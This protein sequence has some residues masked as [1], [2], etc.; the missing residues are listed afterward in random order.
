MTSQDVQEK[1]IRRFGRRAGT[2]TELVCFPHAGGAASYFKPL[3]DALTGSVDVASVQYPGRHERRLE[4]MVDSIDR[5]ADLVAEVLAL[6]PPRPRV[7]FGHSMG[8]LVAFEVARRLPPEHSAAV[9]H[10]VASGRRAPSRYRAENVHTRD[11]AGVIE[12]L[13]SLNGTEAV[14]LRDPDIVEMIL[15]GVR[16]DYRAVETYRHTAGS[17]VACP[18]T[19]LVGDADPKVSLEEAE[20]WREHTTDAFHMHV[21][22]GGHFF[23]GPNARKINEMLTD[24]CAEDAIAG[25]CCLGG[26]RSA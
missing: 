18:I 21:F 16:A 12:E 20:A 25:S 23:L 22:P 2:G 26:G 11:D 5:L 9:R 8:A 3:A 24:L 1:W 10:L 6:L 14:L 17:T 7:L 4:P 13:V 15:P 19:A